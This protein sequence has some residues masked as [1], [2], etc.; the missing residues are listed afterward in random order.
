MHE[1]V[2]YPL[3]RGHVWGAKVEEGLGIRSDGG[4][5]PV[6]RPFFTCLVVLRYVEKSI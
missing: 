2:H 3:P 4:V 1:R 5:L 6:V